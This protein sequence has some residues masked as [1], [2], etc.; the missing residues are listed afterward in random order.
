MALQ[1]A[2]VACPVQQFPFTNQQSGV[3][4]SHRQSDSLA[5]T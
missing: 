2:A 4:W 1:D 3:Y 5:D